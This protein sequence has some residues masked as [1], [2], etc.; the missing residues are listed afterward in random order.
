MV[1]DFQTYIGNVVVS[2]NPYRS[3]PLY[4]QELISEY[5]SRN[6]YELPPHVYVFTSNYGFYQES[7]QFIAGINVMC[8]SCCY[9]QCVAFKPFTCVKHRSGSFATPNHWIMFDT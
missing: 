3:L 7:Y 1:Y 4:T 2:V 5:R 9:F 8:H 6:I